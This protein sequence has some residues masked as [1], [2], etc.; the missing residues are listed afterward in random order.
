LGSFPARQVQARHGM[1]SQSAVPVQWEHELKGLILRQSVFTLAAMLLLAGCGGAKVATV[2]GI[3]QA[4]DTTKNVM[5]V[6]LDSGTSA[7]LILQSSTQVKIGDRV[8]SLSYLEPG[9]SVAAQ[10]RGKVAELIEID[11]AELEATIVA[12]NSAQLVL[13]PYD[14]SQRLTLKTRS[15]SVVRRNNA[16]VSLS[17]LVPGRIARVSFCTASGTVYDVQE[18]PEDYTRTVVPE[19][20]LLEGVVTKHRLNEVTVTPIGGVD[21]KIFVHEATRIVF[22]DGSQAVND[23]I[24]YWDWVTAY[25]D[26]VTHAASRIVIRP[27]SSLRNR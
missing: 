2:Q 26:P 10:A 15:F 22:Q 6:R 20:V 19:G 21:R 9:V 11:L 13:Q 8:V 4:L 7:T 24:L 12:A 5:I 14:S 27:D 3:I 25:M 16:E 17:E 18:M 23:D 1:R